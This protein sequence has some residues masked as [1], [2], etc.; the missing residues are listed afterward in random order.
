VIDD[1]DFFGAL[2]RLVWHED[3][4]IAHP[5]SVPLH[6][7][8]AL[9]RE[10]V[11]VVLTGEGSDELLAGYGKYPRALFNWARRAGSTN[12]SSRR[13]SGLRWRRRSF[14]TCRA[15]SAAT[16]DA[17][18]WRWARRPETM[19]LDNFAGVP[20]AHAAGIAEFA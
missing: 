18:S 20:L 9:A 2:P 7:V 8:S 14:R 5:S 1:G 12:G 19:F 6:F 15:R 3:E 10:H 4:P 17:R 13:C 16:L 11:K